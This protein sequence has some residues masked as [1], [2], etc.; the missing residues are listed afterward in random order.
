MTVAGSP[1]RN[2]LPCA[3]VRRRLAWA[4]SAEA[5]GMRSVMKLTLARRMLAARTRRELC[6]NAASAWLGD[7]AEVWAVC[8]DYA[9]DI[10]SLDPF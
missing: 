10:D 3:C 1:S 8:T 6:T 2:T 7:C 5:Y 9:H 4:P